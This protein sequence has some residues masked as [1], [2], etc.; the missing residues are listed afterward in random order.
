MPEYVALLRGI[1]VGG[2][3]KLAMAD[4]R[5]L[6][7]DVGCDDVR[8]YVQS[9]NAVFTSTRRSA[10]ALGDALSDA[11]DAHAGFRPDVLVLTARD[12]TR[13]ADADPFAGEEGKTHHVVFLAGKAARD[14]AARVEALRAT[15]ERVELTRDALYLHAPDGVARS[16]LAA[17][18]DHALGVSAT[19]RNGRTV[20]A[21]RALLDD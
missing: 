14:A 20:D 6:M 10:R 11:I 1:N 12:F 3:N 9:G 19:S 15:S 7:G 2:R 18:V 17:R 16:K 4:L 21:L 5:R 13:I 8:T